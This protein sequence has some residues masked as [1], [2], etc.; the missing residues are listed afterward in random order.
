MIKL[1]EE[2]WFCY[3]AYFFTNYCYNAYNSNSHITSDYII[4]H[5]NIG[6]NKNLLFIVM[7]HEMKPKKELLHFMTNLM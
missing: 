3:A 2:I 6:E 4:Y 7:S 1:N 5:N